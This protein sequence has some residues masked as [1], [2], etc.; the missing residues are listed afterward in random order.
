[1]SICIN[2]SQSAVGNSLNMLAFKY[3][4]CKNSLISNTFNKLYKNI[5]SVYFANEQD[6]VTAGNIS[7]LLYICDYCSTS[8]LTNSDV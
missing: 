6:C 2:G 8:K 4:F 7:D 5:K 1:M 3:I